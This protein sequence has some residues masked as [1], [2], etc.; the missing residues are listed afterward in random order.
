MRHALLLAAL[1]VLPSCLGGSFHPVAL[2]DLGLPKAAA[3]A[4][5]L[6]KILADNASPTR[7]RLLRRGADGVLKES[8]FERWALPPEEL[9]SRHFRLSCGAGEG[10]E[11][12]LQLLA[13][14]CGGGSARLAC[15]VE[16]RRGDHKQ[17]LIEDISVPLAG[18]SP[19]DQAAALAKAADELLA[20][21]LPKLR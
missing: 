9:L 1:L 21:V 17:K 10:P 18:D 8:E 19:R 5:K 20:R 4:P 3:E 2:H 16:I 15:A 6:G 13:F 7:L 14:E 12:R 11:L